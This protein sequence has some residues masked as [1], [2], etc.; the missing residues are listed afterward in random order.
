MKQTFSTCALLTVTT[1]T[2]LVPV[3]DLYEILNFMTGTS[4]FTHQLPRA[5]DWAG[6]LL[7]AQH[8]HLAE[9]DLPTFVGDNDD[10]LLQLRVFADSL[11]PPTLEVERPPATFVIKNPI[12]EL[13]EMMQPPGETT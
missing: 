5:S 13:E 9:I 11:S 1:G 8:P 7:L 6:P 10:R 4:L 3:K 2:L 12:R